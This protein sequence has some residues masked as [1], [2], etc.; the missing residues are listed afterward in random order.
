[1]NPCP[2]PDKPPVVLIHGMYCGGWAWDSFGAYLEQRGYTCHAPTLRYHDQPPGSKPH[3]RLGTTSLTDYVEDMREFI[4]ALPQKPILVGHSLGGL[5]A[6]KLAAMGLAAKTVLLASAPPAGINTITPVQ[7]IIWRHI[8]FT[9]PFWVGPS[10]LSWSTAIERP[11][12]LLSLEKQKASYARLVPDSKRVFAEIAFWFLD[13]RRASWLDPDKIEGPMLI[14]AG[15]LDRMIPLAMARKIARKYSRIGTYRELP[16]N[17][18][19]LIG[20]PG[21]EETAGLVCDWMEGKA[22]AEAGIPVAQA[23]LPALG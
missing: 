15:T 3:P 5:I 21:W 10:N 2:E 23:V 19:W 14:L 12:S 4:L 17:G 8:L 1:M 22:D 13:W 7:F 20:E 11:L 18:H 9:F 16:T 6:Q